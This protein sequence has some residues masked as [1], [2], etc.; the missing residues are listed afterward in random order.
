[1]KLLAPLNYLRIKHTEK[2]R[3][4]FL[5][6]LIGAVVVTLCY[7]LMSH[8]FSIFG[9][10]GLVTQVNGLLQV[11]IGFYIAALAA[12]ATFSNPTIDQLMA[13]DPPTI[14]ERFRGRLVEVELIRR[15]FLCYLFGYLALVSFIVFSFGVSV[16]LISENLLNFIQNSGL[17][18]FMILFKISF[19]FV[20]TFVLFNVVT[21]TLL[22]LYYLAIR[23]HQ[24]DH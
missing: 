20:Y 15:R 1:M 17:S 21:T 3:Y 10:A 5:Y 23:I 4:D 19:V 24:G 7:W 9:K 11:L 6:P 12:I 2:R 18:N 22:G 8:P 16:S 14:K 13:G